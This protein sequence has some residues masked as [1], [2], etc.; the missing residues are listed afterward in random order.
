M[1]CNHTEIQICSFFRKVAAAF[2]VVAGR[3][4]VEAGL[5]K[6]LSEVNCVVDKIFIT[7]TVNMKTRPKKNQEIEEDTLDEG[8]FMDMPAVGA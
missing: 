6:H 7:K 3:K 1:T 2:H 5:S 8:G 4:S